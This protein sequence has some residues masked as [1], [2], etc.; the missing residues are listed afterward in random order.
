MGSE[1][2]VYSRCRQQV[3]ATVGSD[4]LRDLLEDGCSSVCP[5]WSGTRFLEM[6]RGS[7]LP[8]PAKA[9]MW[10]RAFLWCLQAVGPIDAPPS[11]SVGQNT[12]IILRAL[13]VV[14]FSVRSR[15][16]RLPLLFHHLPKEVPMLSFHAE[17]MQGRLWR[18]GCSG[19]YKREGLR[20]SINSQS[21]FLKPT[22]HN[23]FSPSII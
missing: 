20:P 1:T 12:Y 15:K 17:V 10:F 7:R 16:S 14:L 18:S 3:Q 8:K 4:W 23:C 9:P 21:P 6:R 11:P 13:P 22:G 19:H 2:G 5:T